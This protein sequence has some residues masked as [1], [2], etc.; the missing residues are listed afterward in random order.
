MGETVS[1][2]RWKEEGLYDTVR[3]RGAKL[4]ACIEESE[5]FAIRQAE[6]Y[7]GTLEQRG[8]AAAMAGELG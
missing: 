8:A 6:S 5:V 7:I 3:H 2:F 1:L 4:G